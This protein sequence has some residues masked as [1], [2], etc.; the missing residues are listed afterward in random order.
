MRLILPFL[1]LFLFSETPYIK[2][3]LTTRNNIPVKKKVKEHTTKN[4]EQ[5]YA[6]QTTAVGEASHAGGFPICTSEENGIVFLEVSLV[7]KTPETPTP[8][9]HSRPRHVT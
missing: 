1:S 5:V 8:D 3:K 4:A 7:A 6:T 9:A 2:T